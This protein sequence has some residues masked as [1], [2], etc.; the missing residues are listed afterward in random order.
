MCRPNSHI[1]Q[2]RLSFQRIRNVRDCSAEGVE[3][4]LSHIV[5][6]EKCSCADLARTLFDAGDTRAR[7]PTGF[8]PVI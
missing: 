4:E 6:L 2:F 8:L 1:R 7:A 3:F 5:L